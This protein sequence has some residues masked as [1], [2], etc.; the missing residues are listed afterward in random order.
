VARLLGELLQG[1]AS[2]RRH[3]LLES[4]PKSVWIRHDVGV[5]GK[6]RVD[7]LQGKIPIR[8][9]LDYP[10]F[11]LPDELEERTTTESVTDDRRL[12]GGDSNYGGMPAR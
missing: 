6:G 5:G 10:S 8:A 4:D 7:G 9:F 2:S 11:G 1:R 12:S 3:H